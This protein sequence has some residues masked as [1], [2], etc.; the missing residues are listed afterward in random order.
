[1]ETFERA[2]QGK[3]NGGI[4]LGYDSVNKTLVVNEEEAAIVRE[5]FNLAEQGLGYKSIVGHLNGKGYKTKK[6]NAFSVNGVKDILGNPIYIGKV[7]FNQTGQ[8]NGAKAKT[9]NT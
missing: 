3:F 6:G 8:K 1:M 9:K 7:R 2:K 5:I 4:C